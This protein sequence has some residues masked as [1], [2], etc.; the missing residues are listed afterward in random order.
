MNSVSIGRI[1]EVSSYFAVAKK[2]DC[3]NLVLFC[4]SVILSFAQLFSDYGVP[5]IHVWIQNV[6]VLSVIC[7]FINT[8]VVR[9]YLIPR[10]EGARR[11]QMLSNAFNAP[12]ISETTSL[13]YNNEYSPSVQRLGA[14][15][16][17]NSFFSK[18]I[19]ENMLVKKRG[20]STIYILL[21]LVLLID[22]DAQL[23]LVIWV[24]QLIFSGGIIAAWLNLELLRFRFEQVYIQLRAHFYGN[25]DPNSPKSIATVLDASIAYEAAKSSAGILLS[26]KIFNKL[27]AAL[28]REW[29][30]IKIDL[31]MNVDKPT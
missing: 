4:I 14:N 10:A 19:A 8:L 27:N 7:H 25:P 1:D 13:Y 24:T 18:R 28:T 2:F 23:S 16:M 12:L 20:L 6:F 29:D 17:E 26:S 11:K 31:N 15:T 30:K 9:L 5:N 21:W 3:I 22:R